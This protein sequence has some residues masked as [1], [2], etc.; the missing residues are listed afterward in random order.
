MLA[1]NSTYR[2]WTG[3]INKKKFFTARWGHDTGL[4]ATMCFGTTNEAVRGSAPAA[5]LHCP[6]GCTTPLLKRVA[7]GLGERRSSGVDPGVI[8]CHLDRNEKSVSALFGVSRFRR[9]PLLLVG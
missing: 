1:G 6:G 2:M 5:L 9:F 7:S 4:V 3:F 8:V